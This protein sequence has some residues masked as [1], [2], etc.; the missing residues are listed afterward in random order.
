MSITIAGSGASGNTLTAIT[1]ET[2]SNGVS[3]GMTIQVPS[4]S[5]GGGSGAMGDGNGDLII[6]IRQDDLITTSSFQ[7]KTI[8]K[9]VKQM[10]DGGSS[11]S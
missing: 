9:G 7:L 5:M 6:T 10:S 11:G 1:F 8:P 3:T 4:Q 2:G